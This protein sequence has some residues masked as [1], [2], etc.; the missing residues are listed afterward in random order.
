[1]S[2][3]TEAL[4]AL[5]AE[6]SLAMCLVPDLLWGEIDMESHYRRVREQVFPAWSAKEARRV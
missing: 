5:A 4:H 6:R 2:Y 3:D 1:M